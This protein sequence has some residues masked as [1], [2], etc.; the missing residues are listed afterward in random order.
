[1]SSESQ[2][3][4]TVMTPSETPS[5]PAEQGLEAPA[6][7]PTV[8]LGRPGYRPSGAEIKERFRD[9]PPVY[10]GAVRLLKWNNGHASGMVM[11]LELLEAEDYEKHPFKGLRAARGTKTEGQRLFLIVNHRDPD[12][13]SVILE[14]VY[15][16]EAL[17]QWWAEDCAEGYKV[18]LRLDDGPDAAH[19]VHPCDGM[20]TGR[21]N[22]ELLSMIGW[23]IND[24]E[25][26]EQPKRQKRS[27]QDM[28]PTQ[29]AHILCRSDQF[30]QFLVRHEA[31]LVT[32][33]LVREDIQAYKDDERTKYCECVIKM[34]CQI[35]SR[36]EFKGEAPSAIRAREAWAALV[37][38][39]T[40]ERW[41][42]R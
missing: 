18:I 6:L 10:M 12:D 7:A 5:F 42:R 4:N 27:F 25:E 38:D 9:T 11:S 39:Y 37:D 34:H 14:T 24:A 19:K 1:M 17:L 15:I 31:R 3:L 23:A 28:P 26:P 8:N 22:G 13:P 30:F 32:D 2:T 35:E 21:K 41:N 20:S 16:G 40:Q 33:P 36:A 29:Q